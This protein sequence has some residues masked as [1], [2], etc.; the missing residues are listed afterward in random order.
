MTKQSKQRPSEAVRPFAPVLRGLL[1]FLCLLVVIG[2]T[3]PARATRQETSVLA[4]VVAGSASG[5]PN[6][7]DTFLDEA[8]DSV[9]NESAADLTLLSSYWGPNIQQWSDYIAILAAA[10][11]FHPD[12]I[13]AV[14]KHESDGDYQVVSHMGAVGLMGIMPAGPGLEWR[15]SPEELLTPTVN[16]RWGMAILSAIVRQSGGDVY[17]ALAAYNGGWNQVNSREPRDYA[18]DVL[19]SYARALLVRSG[20]D[21][22]MA[23]QWTVAIEMVGG[24]MPAQGFL[25]LGNQPSGELQSY[26]AHTLYRYADEKSGQTYHVRGYVVPIS[27][28]AAPV[29]AANLFDTAE[30]RSAE[31]VAEPPVATPDEQVEK[32]PNRD[33]RVLLACLPRLDR[34]RGHASTR[35]FAPSNCPSGH[36]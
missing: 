13:A 28:L 24:H 21:P 31:L 30:A 14:I 11:G 16:L 29:E 33:P 35:W 36:R 12:F 26:A 1:V 19:D 20:L 18:A 15:P 6:T 25:V 9:S 4:P 17:S 34:L 23:A 10:Y 27:S 5:S 2:L 3:L 22:D 8:N 7:L 32:L